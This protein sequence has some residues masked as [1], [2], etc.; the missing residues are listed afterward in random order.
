MSNKISISIDRTK[1]FNEIYEYE[2]K[3]S[4]QKWTIWYPEYGTSWKAW[5]TAQNSMQLNNSKT[6]F[7]MSLDK[8]E[9]EIT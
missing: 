2:K 4:E 3:K 5:I 8:A 9:H 7:H 6:I 1:S